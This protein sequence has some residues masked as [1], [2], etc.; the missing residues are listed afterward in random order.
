[1]RRYGSDRAA[2][3][4]A[5]SPDTQ[6]ACARNEERAYFGTAPTLAVMNA[7]WGDNTSTMWLM[8]QLFNLSEFCGVRDKMPPDTAKELARVITQEYGYLKA[9]EIMLFFHRFKA[10]RYGRFYGAVDPLIV[11]TTLRSRF[12]PER[13]AAIESHERRQEQARRRQWAEQAVPPPEAFK[14]LFSHTDTK[15]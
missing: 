9:T 11:T 13:E 4:T 2:L 15:K 1:M 6:L 5:L 12:L 7:A 10:G 3:I 8:P 14:K